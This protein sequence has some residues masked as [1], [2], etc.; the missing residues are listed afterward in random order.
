MYKDSLFSTPQ[1]ISGLFEIVF[2][3]NVMWYCI[4]DPL[5]FLCWGR[6]WD[7]ICFLWRWKG[8]E[9]Q[10]THILG[11]L[12]LPLP[13][14]ALCLKELKNHWWSWVPWPNNSTTQIAHKAP[15]PPPR[16]LS[17]GNLLWIAASTL[18]MAR[19]LSM[20]HAGS[21]IYIKLF[22]AFTLLSHIHQKCQQSTN[23]YIWYL[24]ISSHI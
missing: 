20:E 6:V 21:L 11:T 12:F 13:W 1:V 4:A 9:W 8:R 24:L 18:S 14:I 7:Y 10:G 19:T 22:I 5:Y 23:K 16:L 17:G 2:L 15:P 3:T